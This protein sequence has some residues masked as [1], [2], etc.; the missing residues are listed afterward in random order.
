MHDINGI[1][2]I[3]SSKYSENFLILKITSFKVKI[4]FYV[5]RYNKSFTE[6]DFNPEKFRNRWTNNK[7]IPICKEQ[8]DSES[9]F[10]F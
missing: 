7:C 6:M 1:S 5:R 3:S 2:E 4:I 10:K 8:Q 9:L